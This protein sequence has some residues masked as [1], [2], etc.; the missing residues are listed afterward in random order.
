MALNKKSTIERQLKL[1]EMYEKQLEKKNLEMSKK[2][3]EPF[4]LMRTREL[5]RPDK[6]YSFR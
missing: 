5:F 4:E 3:K 2:Q 1:L 6:V